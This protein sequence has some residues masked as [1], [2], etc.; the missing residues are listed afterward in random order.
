MSD[1][2]FD[3]DWPD[4]DNEPDPSEGH[5]DLDWTW[6]GRLEII[7][8][9]VIAEVYASL[10]RAMAEGVDVEAAIDKLVH[11]GEIATFTDDEAYGRWIDTIQAFE[12]TKD[13]E[14]IN[15]NEYNMFSYGFQTL[16]GAYADLVRTGLVEIGA[17]A[18]DRAA[19]EFFPLVKKDTP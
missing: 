4:D 3:N 5:N 1:R 19:G 8:T 16:A 9:S 17:I 18:F 12:I 14:D 13:L 6:I 10:D 2:P 11:I 7:G 15:L